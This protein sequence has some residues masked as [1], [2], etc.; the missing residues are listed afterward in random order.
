VAARDQPL[1]RP[2]HIN[3]NGEHETESQHL[4]HWLVSFRASGSSN[5]HVEPAVRSSAMMGAWMDSH[6]GG[7]SGSPRLSTCLR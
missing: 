5:A 2:T 7:S 3:Q 4:I 6:R 1:G